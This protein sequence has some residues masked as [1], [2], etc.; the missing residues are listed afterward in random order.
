MALESHN[1]SFRFF[2]NPRK[3]ID[4]ILMGLKCQVPNGQK[5]KC[6]MMY[7][8][9]VSIPVSFNVTIN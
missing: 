3:P 8:I 6:Q 2:Y 4:K 9:I 5:L 1:N 7:Q